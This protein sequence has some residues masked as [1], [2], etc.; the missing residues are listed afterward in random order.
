MVYLGSKLKQLRREKGLT[1]QQL[2]DKLG[3]TKGSISAYETSAKYP[4]IDV[5]R[6][7]AIVLDTSADFLL[8]LSDE[9]AF[10]LNFLTDEQIHI[11]NSLI[12]EFNGL[13]NLT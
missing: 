6:Q 4:S 11:I 10:N 13:N 8:G 9:R 3:L 2:A 1:Q 12:A 5:L 7:M